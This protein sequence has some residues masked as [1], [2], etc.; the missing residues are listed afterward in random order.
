MPLYEATLYTERYQNWFASRKYYYMYSHAYFT[1]LLYATLHV[2]ALRTIGPDVHSV[3]P[4]TTT[5]TCFA[6]AIVRVAC[7]NVL[8]TN[9]VMLRAQFVA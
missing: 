1:V 7:N 3:L 8:P 2:R 5:S 6:T 4:L 9:T